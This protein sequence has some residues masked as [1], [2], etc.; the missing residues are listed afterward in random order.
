[1]K[2]SFPTRAGVDPFMDTFGISV[3]PNLMEVD[4]HVL[5]SPNIMYSG[6]T[7]RN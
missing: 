4:G 7:V 6:T 1:M 3:D 5:K 2:A